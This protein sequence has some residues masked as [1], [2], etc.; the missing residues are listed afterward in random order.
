M[1]DILSQNEVDAL[2]AAVDEGD[3]DL[4]GGAGASSQSAPGGRTMAPGDA[5]VALYDFKRPERVSTDQIRSMEAL[6][7][8]LARRLGASLSGYLRTIVDV[9]LASVEQL[10]YQEFIMSLPN[11]TCFNLV[12]CPPLD[13]K[14]VMEINPS[15]VFPIIDKTLGG[16]ADSSM[17]IPE[18]EMTGIE[19]RLINR[20]TDTTLEILQEIWTPIQEAIRFKVTQTESN[21]QLMQI[22]PPNE[23]VIL[24]CFEVRMGECS[25]MLNLCIPFPVI[26]P[27]MSNLSTIQTWFSYRKTADA[28]ECRKKMTEGLN[29]TPLRLTCFIAETKVTLKQVLDMKPGDIITTQK[30]ITQP[31]LM[32][33]EGKPKYL[34]S[35]GTYKMKKAFRVVAPAKL[36]DRI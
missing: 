11:P 28:A 17:T 13:G 21:P 24:I 3:L 5:E 16:S 6:H 19:L 9:T 25:G 7:E 18:R 12:E 8:V 2:L 26:E 27:V 36:T 15:I 14:I 31:L 35:P 22:V 20:I 32:Q 30:P 10:T 34:G 33:I 23:V 29:K 1:P 4:A